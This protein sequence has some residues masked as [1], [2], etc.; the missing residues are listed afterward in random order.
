M[1]T[2]D[3]SAERRVGN[4]AV[5]D[6]LRHD[7]STTSATPLDGNGVAVTS[8]RGRVPLDPLNGSALVE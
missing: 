8:K 1:L 3:S 2:G 7:G 5:Q 6:Q 4:T